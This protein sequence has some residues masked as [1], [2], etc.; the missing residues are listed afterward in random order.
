MKRQAKT[1]PVG[2]KLQRSLTYRWPVCC[3]AGN[4]RRWL[5]VVSTSPWREERRSMLIDFTRAVF[6]RGPT[7]GGLLP[8]IKQ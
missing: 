2:G 6:C 5:K 4:R 7:L 3:S 1:T 8:A